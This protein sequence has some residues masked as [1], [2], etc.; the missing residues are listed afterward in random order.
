MYSLGYCLLHGQGAERSPANLR[1]ASR[2]LRQAAALGEVDA[3]YELGCAYYR[4]TG[5][6]RS[7]RLAM[8]WL[9]SAARLGNEAA[10]AFLERVE[11]G[12]KLN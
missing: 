11:R 8:K 10:Q 9:R 4:G 7:L 2:W 6:T 1:E 5:L 3:Q 12:N